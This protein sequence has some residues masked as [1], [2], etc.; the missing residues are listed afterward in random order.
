M[1]SVF[2]V[3]IETLLLVEGKNK[4]LKQRNFTS[5]AQIRKYEYECTVA[6]CWREREKEG[7]PS[8]SICYILSL[9]VF[10]L[11]FCRYADF[12]TRL[13]DDRNI[14][15]LFERALSLLPPEES[16]EVD[17]KARYK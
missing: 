17:T 4:Q 16:A 5:G 10:V 11:R 6:I 15:A 9:T 1:S 14:R 3:N 8:C 7:D 12:L 2:T 13:N